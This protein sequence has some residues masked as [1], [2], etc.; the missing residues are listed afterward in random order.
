VG[1]GFSG[2]GMAIRLKQSGIDDFVVLERE[3]DVGGTWY[4]NTY[5][6]CQCD[7]PS[8]LYSFSF[9]PNPEWSR[10]YSHQGEIWDYLRDCAERF[11]ITPHI[12][13]G[14]E[15]REAAWD[16][17]RRRWR[18]D[19]SQGEFEAEVLI[20]G[21]G[22]LSTPRLPNV[23]GIDSFEGAVFHSATWNHDH[24]LSGERVASIGTGAS[25][26]QYVPRI[27]PE[28]ERLYVFQRTPPWVMP[29]SDRPVTEVERR[30]YRRVP[31]LQK[32][33]RGLVYLGREWLVL[34][35]A[36]DQRV[37]K[38]LEKVARRHLTKG[39]PDPE[40]RAK[41]TPGY[42]LGCKRILPS[43]DWYPT[44]TKPNVEV[45]TDA[46]TEVKRR[47]II[48]ADGTERE[49]DTIICGTGFHVTD[50][51]PARL[52]RGKDGRLLS[53]VW[54]E[55]AQAYLGT[56][57]AG[58]PNAF[59]LTGPNTGL[60]HTSLVYMIESQV[61]YVLDCIRTMERSGI[62]TVEVRPEVQ[63]SFNQEVQSRMPET[64]WMTGGCS[65]W[66]LDPTGRN[67]TLWPDWTFRFRQRTR[68]FDLA[69]YVAQPVGAPAREAAAA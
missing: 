29:H 10:T 63:T 55:S 57:V 54:H 50:F 22:G 2:L 58:F 59:M 61:E 11:G 9:A 17:E 6:G 52:L 36:R 38:A 56:T 14:Q 43:N 23:P 62:Q 33:V 41:L 68:R 4:V 40:L 53:E 20:G 42:T 64:V 3:D 18:I 47:S 16:D 65:S 31:A 7:V 37:M 30:V 8:H 34:G 13:F 27:Q 48:T 1:A 28:V 5:P 39:V 44:L 45:V 49:V 46:I 35:F 21:F 60:G 69:S 12:R 26:I 24:D 32:L 67:T 51:P 15:L 19:T 66:Y 25:A